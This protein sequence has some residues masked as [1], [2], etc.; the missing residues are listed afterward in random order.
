VET[1][2]PREAFGSG[3]GPVSP[4]DADVI[5]SRYSMSVDWIAIAYLSSVRTVTPAVPPAPPASAVAPIASCGARHASQARSQ[6]PDGLVGVLGSPPSVRPRSAAAGSRA[7]QR[8]RVG[9]RVI[10]RRVRR[11]V[12]DRHVLRH[13][14]A[15]LDHHRPETTEPSSA[16]RGCYSHGCV[17]PARLVTLDQPD[18]ADDGLSGVY[19]RVRHRITSGCQRGAGS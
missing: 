15:V 6:E 4:A 7:L 13:G 18:D 17:Y 19:M 10:R 5:D 12:R 3:C 2:L 16:C 9:R 11:V 14:A 8:D 1:D